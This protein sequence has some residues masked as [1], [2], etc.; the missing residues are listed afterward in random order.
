MRNCNYLRV[1]QFVGYGEGPVPYHKYTYALD[2]LV[3]SHASN[4][5]T[6]V[7][8][9]MQGNC[10]S[11]ILLSPT[12]TYEIRKSP[13]YEFR[14]TQISMKWLESILFINCFILGFDY[15]CSGKSDMRRQVQGHHLLNSTYK[16]MD[17]FEP[18]KVTIQVS[19]CL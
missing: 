3:N 8:L 14:N 18:V 4:E 2:T 7:E 5:F 12:K 17:P 13:V 6:T 15:E 16:L 11:R 1:D 19:K 10:E 9:Y